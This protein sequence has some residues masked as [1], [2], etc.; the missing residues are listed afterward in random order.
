[1]N[2][3]IYSFIIF[4]FIGINADA[5]IAKGSI[6]LGGQISYYNSNYSSVQQTQK[7][8]GASFI[9]SVGKTFKENSVYGVNLG[10]SPNSNKT[11]NVNI[12][13][14]ETN[15]YN[16]GVFYRKY[17]HLD[18]DFY[19]FAEF[20]AAYNYSKSTDSDS[21]GIKSTTGTQ[22]GGQ[23]YVTPG[24]SYKLLKNFQLEILI[25]NIISINYTESKTSSPTQTNKQNYFSFNTSLNSSPFNSLAVGF[26]FIL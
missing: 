18:K 20:G 10:Y 17:K 16:I 26:R 15:S 19:F 11:D 9:I 12:D 4:I 23:L 13:K 3:I 2:K 7:T 14:T 25:P 21:S 22:L 5:Q 6:L 8:T 1:M 24:I